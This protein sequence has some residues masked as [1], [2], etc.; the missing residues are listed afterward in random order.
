M[1]AAV[2]LNLPPLHAGQQDIWDSGA[3]FKVVCCGRRFGK[4]HLGVLMCLVIAT[5]G[6]RAWW[7]AP[8][9]PVA[10]IGWRLLKFLVKPLV[11]ARLAEISESERRIIFSGGGEIQ[12]KSADNPDSLRGEALDFVVMD[13]AAQVK[14]EAWFEALRPALSDR[15][16]GALFIGTPKGMDNWFYDVWQRAENDT[17][18]NWAS[19]QKPTSDNPIIDPEEIEEARID[20]GELLFSQE[21]LAQFIVAGGLVFKPEWERYYTMLGDT[22]RYHPKSNIVMHHEGTHISEQANLDQCIRFATV[23]LAISQ[24]TSADFTVI[25]SWARTKTKR[26]AL[27]GV[28]RE[29]MEAPEI[30]EAMEHERNRWKLSWL[31]VEKTAFQLAMVQWGRRLNLPITELETYGKDKYARA[32]HAAARMESGHIWYPDHGHTWVQTFTQEV[33]AFDQAKH[34]DQVDTLS[35]AAEVSDAI[36][37]GPQLASY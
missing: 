34:D 16:G 25:S 9:Y 27:L 22:D 24:R 19:W 3:R 10:N 2:Q 1:T 5:R 29:R 31:G 26:L 23:D 18:G 15:K 20:L 14:P 28:R 12:V 7:V 13:E 4:T 32:L 8:A 17:T 30:M 35:Y 6:G 36:W 11:D 21:Y 33:R 37:T